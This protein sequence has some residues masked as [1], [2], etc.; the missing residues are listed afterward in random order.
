MDTDKSR[1]I[2]AHNKKLPLRKIAAETKI[3]GL[4]LKEYDPRKL[5]N[6]G[7]IK[8]IFDNRAVTLYEWAQ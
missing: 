1:L 2:I 4:Q 6:K 8:K 7:K 5:I 3:E